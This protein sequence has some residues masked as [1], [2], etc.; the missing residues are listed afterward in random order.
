MITL[1]KERKKERNQSDALLL[2]DIYNQCKRKLG[3][4]VL[5]M[6][7]ASQDIRI[8]YKRLLR[9]MS[10]YNTIMVICR[11]NAYRQLAKATHKHRIVSKCLVWC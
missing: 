6:V 11:K 1:Q 3:Y 5:Y 8:N 4:R 9:L 10:K 7:L 2:K